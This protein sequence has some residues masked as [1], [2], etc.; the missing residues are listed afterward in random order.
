MSRQ[1]IHDILVLG[2]GIAGWTAAAFAARAK[3][4]VAVITRAAPHVPATFWLHPNL[5]SLLE[6]LEVNV[7]KL[8]P[9]PF[10]GLTFWAADLSRRAECKQ[11]SG[12]SL[13]ER[14]QLRDAL[15]DAA[16]RA[17]AVEMPGREVA[18]VDAREESI[19][20]RGAEGP[21]IEGR[22]LLA[23]DGMA[24]LTVRTLR[25]APAG[26]AEFACAQW[27]GPPARKARGARA[28]AGA[29]HVVLSTQ[30]PLGFASIVLCEAGASVR[31]SEPG[32]AAGVSA[33]LA[34]LRERLAGQ[35]E[36]EA[37]AGKP[38]S[39]EAHSVPR[40]AALDFETHVAKRTLVIGEAGGFVSALG[41]DGLYPAIA[42]ARIAAE[43]AHAALDQKH[44][45]DGL[46]LFDA[47]WRAD[48]ADLL[49]LPGTDLK[50]L[51]PLTFTNAAIADR[52]AKA[53]LLGEN[54]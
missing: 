8:K 32:D 43:V 6:T 40:G 42:S 25:M 27:R 13:V 1:P 23:A 41:Q 47:R 11:P 54:M 7:D 26:A 3:R 36:F 2:G 18:G 30:G 14:T 24:S 15:R 12:L 52:M 44:V 17:G 33:R 16:L 19:R 28:S 49:R 38:A 22:L 35:R 48:L 31:L 4:K 53:F 51:L 29:L 39:L 50:F 37:L 34:A 10:S 21:P 20:L 46:G 45:Q 5:S 9:A